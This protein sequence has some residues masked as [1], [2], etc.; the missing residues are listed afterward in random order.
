MCSVFFEQK[1]RECNRRSDM[2][3]NAK[4]ECRIDAAVS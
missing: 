4:N 3:Q 1:I 2:K